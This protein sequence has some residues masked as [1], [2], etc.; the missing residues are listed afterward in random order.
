MNLRIPGSVRAW[1]ARPARQQPHDG[2]QRFL[3]AL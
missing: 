1:L 3:A 2:T